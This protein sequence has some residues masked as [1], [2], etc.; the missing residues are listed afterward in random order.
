VDQL[1][2]KF[3]V[4]RTFSPSDFVVSETGVCRLHPQLARVITTLAVDSATVRQVVTEAKG[5]LSGTA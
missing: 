4:G 2:L 3:V 1:L 5:W